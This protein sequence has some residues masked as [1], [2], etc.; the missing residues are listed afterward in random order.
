MQLNTSRDTI[1]Y[2]V[3]DLDGFPEDRADDLQRSLPNLEPVLSTRIIWTGSVNEGPA[4]FYT[5]D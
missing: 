1:A 4:N 2:N 5:K 3:I